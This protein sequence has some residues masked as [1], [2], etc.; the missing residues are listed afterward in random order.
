MKPDPH[1]D[2]AHLPIFR[3]MFVLQEKWVLFVL[4]ELLQ[5]GSLGFNELTRRSPVNPTTLAQRLDLLEREGLVVRTVHSAIPPKTSYALSEKGLALRPVFEA[6][7]HWAA[8]YPL[9]VSNSTEC[10]DPAS[11]INEIAKT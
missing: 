3:S 6:I 2:P 1:C 5:Q 9:T 4:W 7:D 10:D 8:S 11:P